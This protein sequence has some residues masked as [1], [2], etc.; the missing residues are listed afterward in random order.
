MANHPSPK[1]SALSRFLLAFIACGIPPVSTAATVV[2]T[3]S[4]ETHPTIS[5]TFTAP[6]DPT[7]FPGGVIVVGDVVIS[8]PPQIIPGDPGKYY[9]SIAGGLF[10]IAGTSN[11]VAFTRGED[12]SPTNGLTSLQYASNPAPD[13]TIFSQAVGLLGAVLYRPSFN[14]TTPGVDGSNNYIGVSLDGDGVYE[15]V[16]RF[17]LDG[18]NAGSLL[19]IATNDDNSPMSISEGYFAITGIPETSSV[20]LIALGCC[21]LLSRRKR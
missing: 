21:V 17:Y 16:A 4:G 20:A 3:Y 2:T 5:L 11:S 7:I 19:S 6:T 15:S 10:A 12:I 13:D 18:V 9:L 8:F 1:R 14:F